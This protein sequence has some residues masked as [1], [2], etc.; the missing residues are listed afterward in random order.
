[1]FALVVDDLRLFGD[2]FNGLPIR[3]AI[4]SKQALEILESDFGMIQEILLDHDLG[5][6]DTI[7]PVVNWLDKKA[8]NGEANHIT[9][10]RILTSNPVGYNKI[11]LALDRHF[12][13]GLT[14][15]HIGLRVPT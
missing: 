8:Y 15:K 1:M 2:Q 11:M 9:T 13:I 14:P 7:M 10:I 5:G 3:Y 12:F 4:N 6:D